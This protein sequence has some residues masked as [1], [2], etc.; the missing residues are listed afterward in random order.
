M[1]AAVLINFF[2]H[3]PENKVVA[4]VFFFATQDQGERE[5][6]RVAALSRAGRAAAVAERRGVGG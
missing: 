6:P 1:A 2:Q 4:G 3:K 5:R